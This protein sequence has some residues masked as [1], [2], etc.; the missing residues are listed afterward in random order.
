MNV[1]DDPA[2]A[3]P[4]FQRFLALAPTDHPQRELV[5]GALAEAVQATTPNTVTAP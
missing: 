5:T 3:V 4:D 2:G 1:L